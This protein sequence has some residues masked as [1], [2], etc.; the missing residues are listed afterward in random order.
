MEQIVDRLRAG[1][2]DAH[3]ALEARLGLLDPPLDRARFIA[4]L[5]GFQA[6]HLA[7]EPRME[8][9]LGDPAFLAPRRKLALL[10]ADLDRL[11]AGAASPIMVDMAW[12]SGP[13]QAWGSLYVMEG[14]TLGGQVISKALRG[15]DWA[16]PGGLRYF[17]PYGRETAGMWRAFRERIAEAS[18]GVDPE[19][20][21]SAAR[22]TFAVLADMLPQRREE[23]AA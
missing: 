21:V 22:R 3:R 19:A 17:N 7:W 23:A 11:G 1:T 13:S 10:A 15:A 18:L 6:F 8:A 14:S 4:A 16:P 9:L 20:A 2:A 5:R 12:L